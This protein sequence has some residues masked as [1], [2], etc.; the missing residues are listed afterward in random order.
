MTG[1]KLCMMLT[2]AAITMTSTTLWSGKHFAFAQPFLTATPP[3]AGSQ[4]GNYSQA[5]S[6]SVLSFT[7]CLPTI[8]A[9]VGRGGSAAAGS[10]VG[11]SCCSAFRS[12]DPTCFCELL[13]QARQFVGITGPIASD[14]V[15]KVTSAAYELPSLCGLQSRFVSS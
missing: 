8:A 12:I 4:S 11:A 7:P 3:P 5:C 1:A 9:M 2:V 13:A 10:P 14:M 15:E 6:A